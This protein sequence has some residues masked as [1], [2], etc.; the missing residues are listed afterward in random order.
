M[1]ITIQAPLAD[2]LFQLGSGASNVGGGESK[3][4]GDVNAR[5]RGFDTGQA[6]P[7]PDHV[8]MQDTS[9]GRAKALAG[10][11]QVGM[12]MYMKSK[13]GGTGPDA[14]GNGY[15]LGGNLT[16]GDINNPTYAGTQKPSIMSMFSSQ[17]SPMP[18]DNGYRD[19]SPYALDYSNN[20]QAP[21]LFNYGGHYGGSTY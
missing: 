9:D 13:M 10:V 19:S 17:E 12:Q 11:A 2:Q 4:K 21:T 7:L 15:G 6:P 16:G 5:P 20:K 8:P 18:R 14:N 3:F 1:A